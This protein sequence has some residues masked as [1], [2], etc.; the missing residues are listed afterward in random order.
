MNRQREKR[1]V[2]HKVGNAARHCSERHFDFYSEYELYPDLQ[3]PYK[4]GESARNRLE[5]YR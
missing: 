5:S 4:Y 3:K 2:I 1:S